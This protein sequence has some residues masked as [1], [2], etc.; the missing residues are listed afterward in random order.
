MESKEL[1]VKIATVLDKKKAMDLKILDIRELT[2][3]G[4]YFVICNGTSSTHI[5]AC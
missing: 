4:D 2:T 5:K 3:L 1:A